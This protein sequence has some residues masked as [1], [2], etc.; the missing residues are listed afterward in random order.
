MALISDPDLLNDGSADNGS[1][2]VFI[3]TSA[4]T[5]KLNTTGQPFHGRRDA[6]G[7]VLVLEGGVAERPSLKEPSSVPLPDDADNG[8]ILRAHRRLGLL[9][10]RGVLFDPHRRMDGPKHLGKRDPEVGG[11]HRPRFD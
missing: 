3:D 5:I 10:R 6:Q 4:K 11:H 1:T 7:V 9:Q 2:E 8:R